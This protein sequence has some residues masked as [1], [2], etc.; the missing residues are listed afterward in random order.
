MLAL[1]NLSY[2]T[3]VE[4]DLSAFSKKYVILPFEPTITDSVNN[5][6]LDHPNYTDYKYDN[7]LVKYY[8]GYVRNGG[9]LIILDSEYGYNINNNGPANSDGIFAELLSIEAGNGSK[10]NVSRNPSYPSAIVETSS[11]SA[12]A[13]SH[14]TFSNADINSSGTNTFY[15]DGNNC[16][17][18]LK[19]SMINQVI[20][21]HVNKKSYGKGNIVYL[22]SAD[23]F[24]P[25][26]KSLRNSHLTLGDFVNIL[27]LHIGSEEKNDSKSSLSSKESHPPRIRGDVSITRFIDGI[28]ISPGHTKLINRTSFSLPHSSYYAEGPTINSSYNLSA[29]SMIISNYANVVGSG[30]RMTTNIAEAD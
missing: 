23:Y 9:N 20:A 30:D 28:K 22:G 26:G 10:F 8:L 18:A 17:S 29:S 4:G 27:G 19:S 11:T 5:T 7:S 3:F 25:Q 14:C 16:N 12:F 24:D 2:D 1:S 6:S 13:S 15:N 21:P